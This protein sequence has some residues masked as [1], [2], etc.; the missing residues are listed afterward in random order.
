MAT[1]IAFFAHKPIG[2][3]KLSKK[4]CTLLN[5]ARHN[6][7]EIQAELGANHGIDATKSASNEVLAGPRVA[8]EVVERAR[9][10]EQAAGV[11]HKRPDYC[12]AIEAVFS[13]HA[14]TPIDQTKYFAD[15]IRWAEQ[16]YKM[17]VLS[18]VVHKDQ[19]APHMHLLLLPLVNGQYVGSAPASKPETRRLSADFFEMV[20]GPAGLKRSNARFMGQTKKNA[21]ARV[22]EALGADRVA[23]LW[24]SIQPLVAQAVSKDPTPW[25][26]A[27]GI[28]L[29]A[30]RTNPT[31]QAPN[32]TPI[33]FK[34]ADTNPIGIAKAD[35]NPIGIAKTP[36]KAPHE[37]NP[38]LCRV[39]LTNTRVEQA[40][41]A[42][43]QAIERHR[44]KAKPLQ[45]APA[46]VVQDDGVQRVRD[47]YAHALPD[48]D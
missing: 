10:L 46:I 26:G 44:I 8:A 39:H 18:A 23:T 27:L 13:L 3:S 21:T 15:C 35:I 7:R 45:A 17:P 16:A 34:Q 40:R 37:S 4:P 31:Q 42:E 38:I 12:Q 6:L 11:V 43:S 20:A 41:D 47:E 22:L 24:A 30:L 29:E 36:P 5:A 9:Q 2:L 33:G 14:D 25:V 32:P 19:T 1:D 28:P 48:Y